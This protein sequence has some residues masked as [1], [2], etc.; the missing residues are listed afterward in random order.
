MKLS[1]NTYDLLKKIAMY[2]LPALATAVVTIF[3][4]W[5]I[6]Y[7]TEIAGTIM[8]IDTLLGAILGISTKNYNKA[9]EVV[10][11]GEP[12]DEFE[13]DSKEE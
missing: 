3:E 4:I 8:A 2:W 9:K 1:N 13:E 11:N 6:P 5:N 7:G 12:I 10:T